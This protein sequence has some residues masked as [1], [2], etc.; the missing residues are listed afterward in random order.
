[1]AVNGNNIVVYK[2]NTTASAWQAI[3]ATKSDELQA[4]C[5]M[6]EKASST[7][8]EWE[9]YNPGR[10][11]WKLNV[12]WLVTAISD[13][14][15]VLTIGERV[16]I[17]IGARGGYNDGAGGLT[18]FAFVQTCKVTMTKG[19][20]SNGSFAFVGDGPLEVPTTT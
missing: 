13:I 19:N 10:K 7:Q 2:Y 4:E 14:E 8:H 6:L 20:L 16:K 1:M 9:E 15:N 12:G 17:H 11:N 5:K 3:A 18:G